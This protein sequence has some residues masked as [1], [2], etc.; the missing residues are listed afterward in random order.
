M[1][2]E[3]LNIKVKCHDVIKIITTTYSNN[4]NARM[5]KVEYRKY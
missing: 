2:L 4:I 1:K 3:N 5:N